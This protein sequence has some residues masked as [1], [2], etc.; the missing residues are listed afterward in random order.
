M[1]KCILVF[2]MLLVCCANENRPKDGAIRV[3]DTWIKKDDIDKVVEM[4]R[5]QMLAAFPQKSLE[6]IPPTVKKNIAR[7]LIANEV[8]LQEA[9]KRKLT[10]DPARLE[11]TLDGIKKQFP[12]SATLDR[13]LVKMGQTR[14][15]MR[16]QV[17]DG[18]LIDTLIKSLAKRSDS[19]TVKECK[20]YYDGNQ[21]KFAPGKRFRA[22][23]VLF[24]VKKDASP[25]QKKAAADKAAKV[26]AEIKAGKDFAVE[27]KKY[28]ED[29]TT[30]KLG[31]DIGWFKKGDLKPEFDMVATSLKQDEV[32]NVFQ[33]DAGIHIIKKTGEE[34]LPPQPFEQE[35]DQI[36][37]MLELKKQN[38]VVKLFVD[39]LIATAKIVYADT[40]YKSDEPAFAK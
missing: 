39:S 27:A 13:E 11:Q 4:Y 15:Q 34:A 23:Q 24:I 21:A 26:L 12:D 29:P 25:A 3:N 9:R 36:K 7:Q 28:S 18:L 8:A 10:S 2:L 31:G 5:Q 38:D 14:Q 20:D 1:K 30:A 37:K 17:R 35:K 40:S 22:S 33:T 19:V 16:D 6:G 32:S